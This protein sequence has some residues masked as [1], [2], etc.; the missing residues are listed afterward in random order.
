MAVKDTAFCPKKTLNLKGRMLDVSYPVVMGIINITPDSFFEGSRHQNEMDLL[1]TAGD[2]MTDGA[3]LLDLGGYSSRP[4]AENV[5]VDEEIARVVPAIAAIREFP[6][7]LIS[8]DTYRAA[9]AKAA[10]EAGAVMINDIS[11]GSLDADM[12]DTV[13]ELK[14]PYI[15]MHM[16]GNP[17][18]MQSMT[19][20]NNLLLDILRD[21]QEK[22]FLLKEKKVRD[23]IVDPG[24]GF[25][26]TLDQNYE[27]LRELRYFTL[28]DHPVLAGM[29]RK[30]MIYKTLNT[31]SEEALNGTT[32]VNSI[33]LMNHVSILRVHDVKEAV[34]AVT[35]FKTTYN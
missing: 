23:I 6:D 20:Y 35:L 4:G 11:G 24:F 8:V 21:L 2:M 19:E 10:V 16:R 7:A 13:A 32:T 14:V 17:Q 3:T 28:L 1:Y 31:S 26:K 33:A 12:F 15:L 30:S 5:S 9:V 27:L 29:S 34:E 18:T 22:I 25:S